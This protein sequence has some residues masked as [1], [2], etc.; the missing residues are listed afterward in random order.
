MHG[1]NRLQPAVAIADMDHLLMAEKLWVVK[2]AHEKSLF[3]CFANKDKSLS[4]DCAMRMKGGN[5]KLS[6]FVSY[7]L[8]LL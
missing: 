3:I 6:I 2:N 4:S 5:A 1:D 7:F 8:P